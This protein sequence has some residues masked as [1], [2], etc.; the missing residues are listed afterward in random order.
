MT[1]EKLMKEF[2]K[3]SIIRTAEEANDFMDRYTLRWFQTKIDLYN[4]KAG[5][6]EA[7]YTIEEGQ[8]ISIRFGKEQY[9]WSDLEGIFVRST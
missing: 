1:A 2:M 9:Q 7:E 8:I 4:E 3:E 6:L 5:Y